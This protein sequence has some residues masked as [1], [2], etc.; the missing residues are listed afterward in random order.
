MC[1]RLWITM[2]KKTPRA[3]RSV[4]IDV[5]FEYIKKLGEG[6]Y[7]EVWKVRDRRTGEI[8]ALKILFKDQLSDTVIFDT[9]REVD[10]LMDI[11]SS[12]VGC[13]SH[14]VCYRDIF[15]CGDRLCIL[16]EYV[17][18]REVYELLQ[19]LEA[20]GTGL[21]PPQL[22]NLMKQT[23]EALAVVHQRGVV[24]RDIKEENMIIKKDGTIVLIDFGFACYFEGVTRGRDLYKCRGIA[25]TKTQMAPELLNGTILNHREW[26]PKADVWSLGITFM[27]LA[28]GIQFDKSWG[29]MIANGEIQR[30]PKVAYSD[31]VISVIINDMVRAR[32]EDRPTAKQ[33][34]SRVNAYE[35]A[36]LESDEAP[37]GICTMM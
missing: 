3:L 26:W 34:L 9:I 13:H 18:G 8:F 29:E 22:R 19:D 16:M 31:P 21:S 28:L 15:N 24:H 11:S 14:I 2:S 4:N 37:P 25:G 7:G 30:V 17:E 32:P 35:P 6:G 12:R 33:L 36:S 5:M 1:I 20:T 10:I 23:L 27:E